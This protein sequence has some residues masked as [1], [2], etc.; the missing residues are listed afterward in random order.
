MPISKAKQ[1]QQVCED[2]AT[3]H[4]VTVLDLDDVSQW[5]IDTGRWVD[6]PMTPQKRCRKELASALRLAHHTDPQLREPR[7]WH[8]ALVP[9]TDGQFRWEW[10]D[11]RF[12]EPNHMHLSQ[13]YGRRQ[14]LDHCRQHKLVTDSYNDNNIHGADLTPTDYNF[15]LDLEEEAFGDQYP[16]APDDDQ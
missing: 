13:Q 15:N 4:H 2:Y 12:A 5:A 7:T 10:A 11:M 14:I 9:G 1:L 16:E 3:E 8:A 6:V